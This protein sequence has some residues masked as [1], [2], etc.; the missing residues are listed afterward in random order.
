MREEVEAAMLVSGQELGRIVGL[1]SDEISSAAAGY[2]LNNH[3]S[4]R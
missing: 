4:L 3:A 2:V 1:Q